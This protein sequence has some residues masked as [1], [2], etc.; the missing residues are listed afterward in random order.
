MQTFIVSALIG[1]VFVA[2]TSALTLGSYLGARRIFEIGGDERTP[3]VASTVAV[4]I[5][6][7]HG[8]ILALVYAQELDGYRDLRADLVE[9]AVAVSDV[10]NDIHRYG[11]PAVAP[12]Q[13][14]LSR[15]VRI[16]VDEEWDRLGRGEGLSPA[17]WVEWDAA[18]GRLLDLE[19]ESQRQR[20]L[21]GRMLDRITAVARLRQSREAT[22]IDRF[23]T[24]FWA[25]AIIGLALV[26][27]PLYV[28]RPTRTHLALI[29]LF[30][31][32]AGVILFFIY[33]FANPFAEPGR[34]EPAA[35][36]RLLAGDLG[37][38]APARR[39]EPPA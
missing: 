33:G 5:A 38:L 4:R 27:A 29:T 35:F 1:L 3:D 37:A 21:G 9:E 34:L 15:Y 16:V 36:E 39:S 18:Y 26:A 31:A 19:P 23:H 22:S 32:Y 28:F 24:L 10:F 8:L 20:F 12:V 11:G 7:L 17:A 6:A 13:A 30:G 2:V 25:P 14:N